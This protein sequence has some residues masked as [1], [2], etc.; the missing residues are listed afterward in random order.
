MNNS[1]GIL[2]EVVHYFKEKKVIFFFGAGISR[3]AGCRDWKSIIEDLLND[4]CIPS[5]IN[6]DDFINS[7]QKNNLK[8]E[9]LQKHYFKAKK[10]KEFW[11]VLRK[12]T[13]FEPELFYLTSMNGHAADFPALHRGNELAEIDGFGLY[14]RPLEEIEQQDHH[15]TDDEPK[16]DISIEGVQRRSLEHWCTSR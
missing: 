3:I 16:G 4:D 7:K 6:K 5:H 1:L 13:T 10:E 15:Q 14:L 12:A 2:D 8:I 9:F 11:G